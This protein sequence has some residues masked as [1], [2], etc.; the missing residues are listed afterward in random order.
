MNKT[1]IVPLEKGLLFL[2]GKYYLLESGKVSRRPRSGYTR[3]LP[4][5]AGRLHEALPRLS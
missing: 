1:K 5:V 3:R 4:I 2:K